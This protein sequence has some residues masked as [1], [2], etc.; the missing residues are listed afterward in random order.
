MEVLEAV[1]EVVVLVLT[2]PEHEGVV[3]IGVEAICSE[4]DER[5]DGEEW[6]E[7]AGEE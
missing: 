4:C 6:V 7:P 1:M 5:G 3:V 2:D